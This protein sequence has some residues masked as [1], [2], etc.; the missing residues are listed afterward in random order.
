M[1][2]EL[3][4][5]P[6]FQCGVATSAW[7]IEGDSA[8]RGPSIWDDFAAKP[9][10]I[11]DATT[12][13]PACDHIAHL[14]DDLDW[15]TWLGIDAY[16]FSI[17]WPR[18]Q[19]TGQGAFSPH[20]ID[21]YNRLIDGLIKRGIEPVATLYHWD[22]P[23]ALGDQGG[24]LER[25]TCERFADYSQRMAEEFGDR[26]GRWATLN[27]PWVSAYL[28][29]AAGIHAPG[30]T[31]PNSAMT[32]A[33]HLMLAHG[34]AMPRLRAA[35]AR[36]C[37]IVLN[38]IPTLPEDEQPETMAASA[39]IDRLHNQ[40]FLDLLAGRGVSD[41][42]R[43]SLAQFTDFAFVGDDDLSTIAAPID[44]IGEN[45]YTVNRVRG[46]PASTPLS[47]VETQVLSAYPGCP[48]AQ[49]K[50]R[51]PRSD[52]GWEVV[53][54]GLTSILHTMAT[55]LPGTPIWIT[56]N[57]AAMGDVHDGPHVHDP[58][59]MDYL[60][61]HIEAALQARDE[62]VDVRGYFAWSLLD[63][64][65]WAEGMTK[66][67]GIFAVDPVTQQRT[68]KDSAHWYRDLLAARQA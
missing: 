42:L 40:F 25:D 53:P 64:I 34:L 8:G 48:P 35:Q 27:E 3:V 47:Q 15:L 68:P 23:S 11:I 39:H 46:L 44:W 20:G 7:Q 32:A 62:G 33:F 26:V 65:E 28:G 43:K 49:F 66:R 63:N 51:E 5:P 37:G 57:G 41:G 24:W 19:P 13:D 60:R 10:T 67:F 29:Y 61:S 1:T 52:M 54:A 50:P 2:P 17:S 31:D 21:F 58:L 36:N 45:Y 12:A 38:L 6:G 4:I 14:D 30:I 55:A 18:V 56:E 9:G 59:R 22:L 16:R